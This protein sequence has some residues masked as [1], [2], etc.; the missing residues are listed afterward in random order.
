MLSVC[1]SSFWVVRGPLVGLFLYG[2]LLD[3]YTQ[4]VQ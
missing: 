3:E 2:V 1:A 4:A